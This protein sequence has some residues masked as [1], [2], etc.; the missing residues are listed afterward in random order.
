[1]ADYSDSPLEVL[2]GIY[3]EASGHAARGRYIEGSNVRFWK[4]YPQRIGGWDNLVDTGV[5]SATVTITI[6]T[7]GVVT[8]NAHGLVAGQSVVFTTTG[9]LPTGIDAGVTYYVIA[10][11]L[12]S[13]EFQI[14]TEPGGSAVNTSDTQSGTHTAT[15]EIGPARGAIAWKTLG[16]IQYLGY[17][18]AYGLYVMTGGNISAITPA[19]GFTVGDVDGSATF[20]WGDSN[21]SNSVWGGVETLYSTVDQ[22]LTW[23]LS[24]WGED[25]VACPRGQGIFAWDASVGAGTP[26]ATISGA[27]TTALGIFVSDINRTL[28]AYGAHDGVAGDPLNV[29]WSDTEDY[30]TW[31]PDATNTAGSIR[32]E[33]GNE[34]IGSIP[35]RGG[36]LIV[37]DAAVYYF[38][39][40]GGTFV[41]SLN[42]ISDGPS[43]ISPHAGV[44]DA[45]GVTFWMGPKSFYFYDGTVAPLP[46]DVHADVFNNI[47]VTQ[48]FKVYCG[49]IKEFSEVIWLYPRTG[50]DEINACVVYNTVDKTWWQ[51]DV[52]RTSWIDSNV[53]ADYPVGWAADGMIYAH[54][55]NDTGDGAPI[56]YLL[57]TADIDTGMGG[58][59]LHQRK[60]VPDYDEIVGAHTLTIVNRG[61]PN[62]SES[63]AGPYSVTSATEQLSVRGR[64]RFLRLRY[65]G[66]SYFR[67]G[68]LLLRV[69]PHG[70]KE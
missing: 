58:A 39:Y 18:T 36:H 42:R 24:P 30:T 29:R 50:S 59:Y 63:T 11:G 9:T 48:R 35:A 66:E 15:A 37:T 47:N 55:Y 64:G 17:G 40:I 22:P 57:E 65:E 60:L 6:D 12:S 21:W 26:A 25:M 33:V 62:R 19:S 14:A 53:V 70:R 43:M 54:E 52:A 1:M 2:P 51:G 46:C 16:N 32:C 28:V 69:R 27:P 41:F 67:L 38:K 4:G 31:T 10:A 3:K 61:Y 23:T 45:M 68:K 44:Q 56:P 49:T 20:G 13:T 8:W 34:I 7:P 5:R